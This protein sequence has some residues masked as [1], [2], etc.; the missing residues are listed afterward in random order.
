MPAPQPPARLRAA[1]LIDVATLRAHLDDPSWRIFD[2]RF[3]LADPLAGRNAYLA[4]HI[5]GARHADIDE[6][7]SGPRVPGVTGRH[8]LPERAAWIARVEAWGVSP[9]DQ[10][11]AYDDAGGAFAARLWWMMRW[12]GHA[13]VAVLD[14]GW[15]AWVDAGCPVTQ[16]VPP[17]PVPSRTDY[18]ERAPLTRV[19]AADDVDGR[20]QILLDARDRARFRGD[21]EPI[22]PVAGHIPGARSAP[23]S[24]NLDARGFFKPKDELRRRFDTLLGDASG[25]D[26]VC[27]CGSGIT[28]AHDILALRHAG[29]DEPVLYAGSWS[30]WINDPSRGVATGD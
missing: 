20:T 19:V 22:D 14:G 4:G 12:I 8:P 2:C 17:A 27:Y 1:T 15:R 23:A 13:A 10:V 6:H 16:A 21:V 30:E 5:P 11:V 26:V 25:K 29:F 24:E 9:D 3:S 28:A 18:A 7:L